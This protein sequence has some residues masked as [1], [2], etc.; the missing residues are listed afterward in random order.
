MQIE[1]D[2]LLIV[3]FGKMKRKEKSQRAENKLPQEH[4]IIF[5]TGFSTTLEINLD[6]NIGVILWTTLWRLY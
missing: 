3:R 1:C 6:I 4:V 5:G 2:L